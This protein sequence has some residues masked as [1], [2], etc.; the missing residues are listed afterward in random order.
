MSSMPR[1]WA[2]RV[3]LFPV[4]FLLAGCASGGMGGTGTDRGDPPA[5]IKLPKDGAQAD[6]DK[7]RSDL[8][9][10]TNRGPT[11][12]HT[13]VSCAG[14]PSVSVD[15]QSIGNTSN[16]N[17]A[18]TLSAPRVIGRIKNN[19]ATQDPNYNLKPGTEYL[20]YLEPNQI[21]VGAELWL[22]ELPARGSGTASRTDLGPI[23]VCHRYQA[24]SHHSDIDF[25]DYSECVPPIPPRFRENR[26][27]NGRAPGPNLVSGLPG[28][29]AMSGAAK[30]TVT[31][32]VW[33]ECDPGCCVGSAFY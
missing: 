24:S 4:T 18:G 20:V 1:A 6:F 23:Q 11:R 8:N 13:R 26:P 28:R 14:C 27:G 31:S 10:F 9:K 25:R 29:R 15:I 17:P 12:A 22:F 3:G 5:E 2:R 16:V 32:G 19:G 7:I 30:L 21:G 33:F